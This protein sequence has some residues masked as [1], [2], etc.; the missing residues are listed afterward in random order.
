M[1][2]GLAVLS[3]NHVPNS[4]EGGDRRKAALFTMAVQLIGFALVVLAL[5]IV[6]WYVE[7]GGKYVGHKDL[8]VENW[9]LAGLAFLIV[10]MVIRNAWAGYVQSSATS[11][12]D[13]G[14]VDRANT[15]MTFLQAVTVLAVLGAIL[16]WAL[17]AVGISAIKVGS[18]ILLVVAVLAVVFIAAAFMLRYLLGTDASPHTA[19]MSRRQQR[20]LLQALD[21]APGAWMSIDVKAVAELEPDLA[22]SVTVWT[23]DGRWYW[24]PDHAYALARYHSWAGSHATTPAAALH[25]QRVSVVA[26]KFKDSI[27]GMRITGTTRRLWLLD[28]WQSHRRV[29]PLVSDADSP[30]RRAGLVHIAHEQLQAAGLV[31]TVRPAMVNVQAPAEAARVRGTREKTSPGRAAPTGRRSRRRQS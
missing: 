14:I 28:A 24:R 21:D 26:G 22:L 15:F 6:G 30:E 2:V 8:K 20:S 25:S 9:L 4:S 3:T 29:P 12:W 23:T 16:D 10:L 5:S 11:P 1:G 18:A 17:I 19:T 27:R 13:R 31:V 7:S